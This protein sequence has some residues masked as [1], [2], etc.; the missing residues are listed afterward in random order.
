MPNRPKKTRQDA[1]AAYSRKLI[2]YVESQACGK[3]AI[4]E[5]RKRL[6]MP[7]AEDSA[8]TD[9]ACSQGYSIRRKRLR[10][11]TA[12]ELMHENVKKGTSQVAQALITDEQMEAE[13]AR[14]QATAAGEGEGDGEEKS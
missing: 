12:F 10:D 9:A 1:F 3:W 11:A 4:S 7:D 6:E 13:L 2:A 14:V 5:L 8:V